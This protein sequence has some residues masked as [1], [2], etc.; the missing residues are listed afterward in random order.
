MEHPERRKW[1]EHIS[2]INRKLNEQQE[3]RV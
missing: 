1:C 2:K 3:V